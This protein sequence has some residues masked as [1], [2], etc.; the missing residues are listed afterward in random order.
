MRGG[1][2]TAATSRPRRIT[3]STPAIG[4]HCGF[5]LSPPPRLVPA[6]GTFSL[7]SRDWCRLRVSS[8]SAP[9]I[10]AHCGY[11]LSPSAIGSGCGYILS[12]LPRL[13]PAAG[14]FSLPFCDWCRLR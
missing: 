13:V 12:P 3:H 11:V 1:G 8:L 6:A 4:A 7:R 5:I 14:T 2:T 10:G 9:A